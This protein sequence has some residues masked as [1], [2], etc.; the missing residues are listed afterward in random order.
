MEHSDWVAFT[1]HT[2]LL[3]GLDD[4]LLQAIRKEMQLITYEAH[5]TICQQGA[6]LDCIYLV[7]QGWVQLYRHTTDGQWLV[8]DMLDRY[9]SFGM[10]S[11]FSE[12]GAPWS[13]KALET[14]VLVGIPAGVFKAMM[15]SDSDLTGNIFKVLAHANLKMA[16]EV[17]HLKMQSTP[18]RL[19]CFLLSLLSEGSYPKGR[20]VTLNL[21]YGK[22]ILASKLGMKPETFSRALKALEQDKGILTQGEVV[23]IPDVQALRV[24]VCGG[25]SG[26]CIK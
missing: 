13:A 7:V 1:K 18:Q 17:E 9:Q 2:L 25:C 3:G 10:E 26:S 11:V 16:Q 20:A 21:P 24:Y 15:P 8:V 6:P 12:G 19:G 5:T 4:T 22:T 14:T 23:T